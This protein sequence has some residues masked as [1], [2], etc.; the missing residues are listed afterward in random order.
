MH[1]EGGGDRW[2]IGD[3]R[4]DRSPLPR[5]D[6]LL[7][8]VDTSLPRNEL[9]SRVERLEL[10]VDELER[11]LRALSG[12]T[13]IPVAGYTLFIVGG[14]GYEIVDR[15][16]IAPAVGAAV[17]LAGTTFLVERM[18]RS[19]FPSDARPCLVLSAMPAE[20]GADNAVDSRAVLEFTW[21]VLLPGEDLPHRLT[22]DYLVS[23][24]EE[25]AVDGREWLVER[26]DL[27]ER[28]DVDETA[29]VPTGVVAVV[30]PDEPS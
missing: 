10:Q 22:T 12:R 27:T 21:D 16:G 8:G 25:I 18:R 9:E 30:R 11:R 3:L 17:E 6:R 19:P 28:D 24:G 4:R 23:E 7:A 13:S 2:L 26:V 29:D 15:D 5:V 1:E 14:R 20:Q